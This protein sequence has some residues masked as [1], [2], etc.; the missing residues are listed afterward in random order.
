MAG[1]LVACPA[2]GGHVR[3]PGKSAGV[4]AK[5]PAVTVPTVTAPRSGTAAPKPKSKSHKQAADVAT[6]EMD[7]DG[8]DDFD[9]NDEDDRGSRRGKKRSAGKKKTGSNLLLLCSLGGG[10]ILLLGGLV[11]VVLLLTLRGG[12][13]NSPAL[14]LV[15]GDAGGFV[16]VR[17]GDFMKTPSADAIRKLAGNEKGNK[18]GIG[19]DEV[20]DIVVILST[21]AMTGGEQ[22]VV[23]LT[24]TKTVTAAMF[25][26]SDAFKEATRKEVNGKTLFVSKQPG[27]PSVLLLDPNLLLVGDE[28]AITAMANRP[29][30]GNAG[31]LTPKLRAAASGNDMFFFGY[32]VSPAMAQMAGP[33]GG[34]GPPGLKL[35]FITEVKGGHIALSEDK[36]I[37][38]R[39]SLDF[40]DGAKAAK[41]K[42]DLDAAL[43]MA[44]MM[45][46][47]MKGQVPG[48]NP[49][50]MA[51][52]EKA[53]DKARPVVVGVSVEMPLEYETTIGELIDQAKPMMGGFM[54]GMGGMPPPPGPVPQAPQ[55]PQP[56]R[57]PR[58]KL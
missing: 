12:G 29:A 5:A 2:C 7:G 1:K 16:L 13:S 25:Q 45:L 21:K 38:G 18:F 17:L 41:A 48:M 8:D 31:P 33:M 54:P 40:A 20:R 32:Q 34:G 6:F 22:P 57:A 51:L 9:D 28:P 50:M 47:N 11:V 19:M 3:L 46:P 14:A 36:S 44:R 49:K 56:Q 52:A 4:T 35:S 58:K 43:G 37:H 39:I 15:P 42:E 30:G 23:A 26:A 53:L 10:G 55:A 24:T 27:Q